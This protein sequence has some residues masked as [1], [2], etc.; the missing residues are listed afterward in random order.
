MPPPGSR[1]G[2][3]APGR[4]QHGALLL[5]RSLGSVLAARGARG[6]PVARPAGADA[7]VRALGELG[8]AG[9]QGLVD[10]VPVGLARRF[11]RLGPLAVLRLFGWV[12]NGGALV[13][14]ALAELLQLLALL[15]G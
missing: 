12:R 8:L 14:H 1:L 2:G 4:G 10:L 13:L 6:R 3:R 15:V 11:G 5:A 9:L 7:E